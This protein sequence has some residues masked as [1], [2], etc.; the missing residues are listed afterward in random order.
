MIEAKKSCYD[1]AVGP[2]FGPIRI[3]DFVRGKYDEVYARAGVI[4]TEHKAH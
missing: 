2:E 3:E 4:P 1:P